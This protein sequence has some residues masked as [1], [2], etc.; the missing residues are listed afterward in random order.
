MADQ[1]SGHKRRQIERAKRLRKQIESLKGSSSEVD[2]DKDRNDGK[3]K[4]RGSR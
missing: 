4:E 3:G 1:S 2:E